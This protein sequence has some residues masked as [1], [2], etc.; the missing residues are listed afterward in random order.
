MSTVAPD[1]IGGFNR[2]LDDQ[3]K[4]P[5]TASISLHQFD[6]EYETVLNGIDVKRAQPLTSATFVPRGNTALMDAIGRSIVD[7]G[8]RIERMPNHER[9]EKVVMVIVTDGRENA[10]KE[11]NQAKVH[12]MITHQRD[13]YAWEFVFLG[14]NQDAI[15][16]ATNLGMAAG[17]AM[18]YA[19]NA[20]GSTKAFASVG[21]NLKKFRCGTV[22]D[23]AYTDEDRLEQLKA[24]LKKP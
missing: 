21:S 5:G 2:F 4:A 14:A 7:T 23:M 1:T 6:H 15:K 12:E 8:S 18:S 3:Q 13:K 17:N 22:M 19:H 9:P 16:A 20:A 10:S 24:G 11:Y